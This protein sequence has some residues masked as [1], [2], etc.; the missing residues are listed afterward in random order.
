MTNPIQNHTP[1]RGNF[2]VFG[3]PLIAE[4]E[5]AEVVDTLRTGWLGTGPKTQQ[6]EEDFRDYIGCEYALG[7]NSCTAGLDLA[8][9]AIG[10][11]QGD[12]VITTPMTFA[13]TANVIV[14]RGAKPV[15][16]D[17]DLDSMNIDPNLIE[18]NITKKTKTI[19]PVHFAGRPCEMDA[20]MDIAQRHN[21]FVIE[22]AAHA[23]EA[24][25]RDRKIGTIA[26]FT[27]FS[28]YVT[29][30]LCTGE[31]G[32]I[33]TNN[34]DW[35][36]RIKIQ[37]L[38]GLSKDAW[39]RYSTDGF[40]PYD[41]LYPGYKYNMTDMQASLGIHQLKQLEDRLLIREKYW[42]KYNEAF[43]QLDELI[44]P[45]EQDGIKHARH[46]YTI[47]LRPERMSI[48]RYEFMEI[49]NS[50]NIGTGVHFIAVH[51]Q[52]YYAKAVGCIRG[53]FPNAEYVSDRTISLPLSA[54]LTDRDTS[55]VIN[56][57][58]E[59]IKRNRKK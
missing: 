52:A 16:V 58:T 8:L 27:C 40:H 37:R 3:A 26:D 39:K 47:L 2:L 36:N 23:T 57:V 32:M 24:K 55:D 43:G 19:L 29:K 56:A 49:L 59:I 6:F 22:D 35:A 33:T 54:K 11:T 9:D 46:L 25:Y 42:R 41:V 4:E 53:D 12:E 34:E 17:I 18:K 13:A 48:N 10:V 51:L 31:G 7:L 50:W 14:H 21:L 38:H 45:T 28:F 30:N 44:I 1:R 5:I 15:F 20:I